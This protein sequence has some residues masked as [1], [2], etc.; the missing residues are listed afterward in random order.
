MFKVLQ[1]QKEVLEK[2]KVKPVNLLYGEE[3]Y[4]IG[5]LADKLKEVYGSSFKL[6]W[7]DETDL[8]DL[9]RLTSEGSVFSRTHDSV[10]FLR[11]FEDFLRRLGRK[12]RSMESF[13]SLLKRLDRTKL[14]LVVERKLS[15]QDLSKEPFKTVSSLGDVILAD[16]LPVSK[17]KEIVRR[18]LEREAGGIDEEALELLIDLCQGDLMVLKTE[19]EKLVAY[20]EGKRITQED[21]RRVCTPWGGYGIFHFLDAFFL[22]DLP[23]SLRALKDLLA[24]GT[25]PLQIMTTLGNYVAKMYTTRLLLER[26]L[27][28]QKALEN[29]GVKQG[30][31]QLKFKD[32]LEKLPKERLEELLEAIYRLDLSVKVY[33]AD[34]QEALENFVLNFALR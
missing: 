12:K 1:Y 2:G 23:T 4:L 5:V 30:F 18:K 21:V 25:P 33:F 9:Y 31:S 22:G 34:P 16:K 29:V 19:T 17:V 10:V 15:S 14:F 32:Y 11:G 13:I 28:L 6:A 20:S 7:G 3:E 24:S 27:D 8:E 26:G